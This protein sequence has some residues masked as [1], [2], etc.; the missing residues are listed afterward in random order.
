[1]A[2]ILNLFLVWSAKLG[3]FVIKK[4][5]L[6]F[7]GTLPGHFV[8]SINK[9]FI[10]QIFK[11]NP[12]IK[13]ILV[14]GTNGKTT[15]TKLIKYLLAKNSY[16]V[17]S[18]ET[19]ANLIN[20]IASK[21]I[22]HSDWK[23][24][25][26]AD[27]AVF[28]IDEYML[29]LIIAEVRPEAILVLNLFRDQ[30]DRY[31]EV[32]TISARWK[33]IFTDLPHEIKL[34]LNGDDPE[35][36]YLGQHASATVYYF[37][38]AKKLMKLRKIPHDADSIYCPQCNEKLKYQAISYSH[39][40]EFNC[41]NCG[42][43]KEN[44]ETLDQIKLKSNLFGQY[45][46]YNINGLSLMLNQSFHIKYD[47][48]IQNLL[49]FKP[50]FGRQERLK[51]KNKDVLILLS[52][53]P[54]GYNQSIE[55]ISEFENKNI[56]VLLVLNDQIPDGKD[57]SWIWDVDFQKIFPLVKKIFIAGERGYDMAIR[58]RYELEKANWAKAENGLIKINKDIFV[59]SS[60]KKAVNFAANDTEK[61]QTLFIL[62]NYSAM[63]QVRSI[64]LNREML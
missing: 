33:K 35:L 28:E 20:G 60:I 5:K 40:G 2:K 44:V 19:G 25:I 37:G 47:N 62:P 18:N 49:N 31:G 42:F 51:Y 55:A 29:D 50:A 64:I 16:K 45:S 56:N 8:L 23:G 27:V 4:F 22:I 59:F 21:L 26:N 15:S 61:N 30:L 14:A 12:Q 24:H 57:I 46:M 13:L 41:Q 10:G 63:L 48:I 54:T 38:L 43:A 3:L 1:M 7:G 39:L 9:H 32:N 11:Y 36:Y 17:I 58:I 53:N 34:Y 6:G 52:K